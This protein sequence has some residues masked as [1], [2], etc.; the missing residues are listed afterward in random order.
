MWTV[1]LRVS[2]LST[3]CLFAGCIFV[4]SEIRA[5]QPC[6]VTPV[7]RI[8]R[9]ASIFSVEQERTL[10]DIEAKWVESNYHTVSD[11]G[12]TAHLNTVASRILSQFRRDAA[13]VRIMLIDTP[14]V[15]AFSAGPERIY[16]SRKMIAL[17]MNDDELAGVLGHEM[18]HILAHENA[19]TV[20]QLF[21]EILRVNAVS[22]RKDISDKLLRILDSMNGDSKVS[23]KVAQIIERQD[24]I[25]QQAADRVALYVMAAAGFSPEAYADLFNRS[26]QTKGNKGSLM[27]D[28]FGANT[29]DQ[30][31]LREINK[32]VGRLP[33]PCRDIV[34]TSSAEFRTWRAAVISGSDLAP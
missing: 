13:Q 23:R 1:H 24:A 9:A 12:L 7:L 18:A 4:A 11:K 34:P 30:R 32:T 17:L 16:V 31:R 22:D 21:R 28:F 27:S 8:P 25:S 14:G 5:Q 19:I 26:G 10:G 2:I 15:D 3:V 20:S 33:R 29:S 6:S